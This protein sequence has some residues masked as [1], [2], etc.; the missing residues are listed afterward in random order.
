MLSAECIEGNHHEVSIYGVST[1]SRT[2]CKGNLFIPLAGEHYD[3][4]DYVDAL[5][6]LGAA[7]SLWQKDHGEPPQGV[8]IILV[9]NT[10]TALQQLAKNYREQCS[11][12]VIGITGSNGKTTT[13]DLTASILSTTYRTAKT[14]GNL[15]NH[16]G[17]PQTLLKLD[18]SIEVVVLEMGM[19]ARGE[20]ELL[21]Q[22]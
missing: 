21:S 6:E 16:I 9:E 19:S 10:L 15:N 11:A 4:H 22:L 1:D 12:Y 18:E 7:A 17:L 20:I 3:G 14:E 2:L 5:F 13:K 8:P